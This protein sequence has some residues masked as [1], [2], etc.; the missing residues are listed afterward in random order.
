MDS[1]TDLLAA[2][3]AVTAED[4]RALGLVNAVTDEPEA[5][6]TSLAEHLMKTSASS[7]RYAERAV[8]RSLVLQMERD[9]PELE[10]LYVQELMKTRDANE[11]IAA[12]L[13]RRAPVF[14]H[15]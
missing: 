2:P 12:F 9:I 5:W 13:E 7:L 14:T 3:S 11:G 6:W 8:R 4:A 10:R 15:S 1:S